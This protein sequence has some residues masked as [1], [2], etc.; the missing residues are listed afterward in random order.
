MEL[1]IKESFEFFSGELTNVHVIAVTGIVWSSQSGGHI[2]HA[3]SSV[4]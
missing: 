2:T 4:I 1:N 3:G